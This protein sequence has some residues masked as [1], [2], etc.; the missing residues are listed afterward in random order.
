MSI[1]VVPPRHFIHAEVPVSLP[2]HTAA[3]MTRRPPLPPTNTIK[4]QH[5]TRFVFILLGN[6]VSF[7]VLDER[8]H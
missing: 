1:P 6:Y 4:V 5:H 3:V 2:Y 7:S 8:A